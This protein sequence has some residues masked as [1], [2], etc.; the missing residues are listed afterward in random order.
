MY[1]VKQKYKLSGSKENFFLRKS[2][3]DKREGVDKKKQTND[4]GKRVYSP[5]K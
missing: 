3:V 5:K 4:I 1:F 2:V